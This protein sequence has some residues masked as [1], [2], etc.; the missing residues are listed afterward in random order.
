[1]QK[2]VFKPNFDLEKKKKN[3]KALL[4]YSLR[5]LPCKLVEVFRS[6]DDKDVRI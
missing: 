6:K 1:M 3:F 5:G 2:V 4:Y